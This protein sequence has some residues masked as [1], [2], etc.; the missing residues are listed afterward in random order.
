MSVYTYLFKKESNLDSS[1]VRTHNRLVM[2][3][4]VRTARPSGVKIYT[5]DLI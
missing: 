5:L 4:Y 1:L 2:I 3:I